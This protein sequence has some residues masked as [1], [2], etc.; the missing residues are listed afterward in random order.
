MPPWGLAGENQNRC[1]RTE[2]IALVSIFDAFLFWRRSHCIGGRHSK[3]LW[4]CGGRPVPRLSGNISRGRNLDRRS[5]KGEKGTDRR[6][7]YATWTNC[8]RHGCDGI[9]IGKYRSH[10]IR[11]GGLAATAPVETSHRPCQRNSRVVRHCGV[12]LGT[13]GTIA[14]TCSE[15]YSPEFKPSRAPFG[16]QWAEGNRRLNG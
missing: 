8:C 7:W 10:R 11:S 12:A 1:L 6:R 2:T 15:K 3:S 16:A 4:P 5:R 9:V 13:S 14:A